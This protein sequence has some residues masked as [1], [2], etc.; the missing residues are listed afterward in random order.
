MAK[1]KKKRSSGRRRSYKKKGSRKPKA[2]PIGLTGG[3]ALTGVDMLTSKAQ[4][5]QISVLDALTYAYPT[6]GD[7]VTAIVD[8][9][10]YQLTQ[11]GNYKY[12]LMGILVSASPNI[13]VLGIVAKPANRGIKRLT[14]GKWGL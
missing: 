7:R 2:K 6:I 4:D 13:P 5:G 8:K 11:P 3:A 14:K 1:R 9:S 10:K 12:A